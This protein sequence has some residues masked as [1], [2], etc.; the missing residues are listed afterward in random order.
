[1]FREDTIERMTSPFSDRVSP[2]DAARAAAIRGRFHDVVVAA[3][4]AIHEQSLDERDRA[5]LSWAS[6]MLTAASSKDVLL[7]MPSAQQLS[8][9][10]NVILAIRRAA[11]SNGDDPSDAI[12]Q[13]THGVAEVLDGQ[14][15]KSA[16]DA[17]ESLRTIFSLISRLALQSEVAAQGERGSRN[18]WAPL[19]TTLTS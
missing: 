14:R 15:S 9:P 12:N 18:R 16:L 6:D 10:G 2:R 8:G 1:M 17:M 4:K 3:S 5:A 11:T 19:T 13:V 7:A